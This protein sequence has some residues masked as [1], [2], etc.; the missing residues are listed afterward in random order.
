M[1]GA[2]RDQ[3]VALGQ[4]EA[5]RLL[6]TGE[7]HV[8]EHLL[9]LE[10]DRGNLV[11]VLDRDVEM[12]AAVERRRFERAADRNR[13]GD[14]GGDRIDHRHRADLVVHHQQRLALRVIDRRVRLR[15]RRDGRLD[16]AGR[17]VEQDRPAGGRAR[18]RTET[19]RPERER[20]VGPLGGSQPAGYR[21]G[22]HVE[23][24]HP[25]AAA[26][27]HAVRRGVEAQIVPAAIGNGI[28]LGHRLGGGRRGEQ[29]G[30]EGGSGS[31][32]HRAIL[33]RR[34][35]TIRPA[36]GRAPG[37]VNAFPPRHESVIWRPG[38]RVIGPGSRA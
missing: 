10:V 8:P 15:P 28:A 3:H 32:A 18:H 29:G 5:G 27:E 17:R 2:G 6:A 20:G 19:G 33:R 13:P 25:V 23:R 4:R 1:V 36:L 14:R 12:P 26:D 38:W 37:G 22:R 7:R 21:A 9:R 24:Q 11:F 31:E 30:D 16:R 35:R 34:Q